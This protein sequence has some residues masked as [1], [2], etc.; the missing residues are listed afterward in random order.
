M[1]KNLMQPCRSLIMEGLNCMVWAHVHIVT[2]THF[3]FPKLADLVYH[4]VV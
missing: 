4:N 3:S 2:L 1:L